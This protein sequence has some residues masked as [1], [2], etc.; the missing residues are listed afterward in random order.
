MFLRFAP[1]AETCP[2]ADFDFVVLVLDKDEED[3]GLVDGGEDVDQVGV[4][5]AVVTD[6]L[7]D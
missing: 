4:A 3:I 1:A 2:P 7:L 6:S 5:F